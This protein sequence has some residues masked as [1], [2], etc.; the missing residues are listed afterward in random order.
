MTPQ[1][2]QMSNLELNKYIDYELEQNPMLQRDE[3]DGGTAT[4][5]NETRDHGGETLYRAE[6]ITS[7]TLRE[8]ETSPDSCASSDG[9]INQYS[10]LIES[11]DLGNA[12]LTR[13]QNAT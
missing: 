13:L 9:Y 6:W 4:T 7:E 12:I 11:V 5:D 8:G 10:T 2:L 1:L 3:N